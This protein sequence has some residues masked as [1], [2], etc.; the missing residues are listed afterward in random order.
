MKLKIRNNL[1]NVLAS[2]L[3]L[4]LFVMEKVLQ[5]ASMM[6]GW[7]MF[8]IKTP[9]Y[10]CCQINVS[11]CYALN[12]LLSLILRVTGLNGSK[13]RFN[14]WNLETHF[15]RIVWVLLC[16]KYGTNLDKS[17]ISFYVKLFKD[18]FTPK[19]TFHK[20]GII[21]CSLGV[22]KYEIWTKCMCIISQVALDF[23]SDKVWR[24]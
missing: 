22:I 11:T 9:T 15:N 21:W 17:H 16:T 1:G 10:N 13:R 19:D 18:T 12:L 24:I 7:N 20:R 14:T 5:T 8:S 23:W 3:P 2:L 6:R 4:F